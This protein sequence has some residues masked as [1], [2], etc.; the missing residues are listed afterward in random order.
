VLVEHLPPDSALGRVLSGPWGAV[1]HLLHDVDSRIRDL[2]TLTYNINRDKGEAQQPEY[3]PAP[4]PTEYQQQAIAAGKT[5]DTT[6]EVLAQMR[7]E[8]RSILNREGV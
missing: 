7:A 1:E 5:G 8:L 3:I 6:A 2:V 4:E